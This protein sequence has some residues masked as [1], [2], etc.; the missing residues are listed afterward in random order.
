M[1]FFISSSLEILW[2]LRLI[3][4]ST[5]QCIY[6]MAPSS[7]PSLSIYIH[8]SHAQVLIHITSTSYACH[9]YTHSSDPCILYMY[10][11]SSPALIPLIS[12][13]APNIQASLM[14]ITYKTLTNNR[15]TYLPFECDSC[16]THANHREFSN[17][18]RNLIRI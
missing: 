6:L 12:I 13:G 10:V 2:G 17:C 16:G 3:V 7:I 1:T 14:E 11:G 8:F 5:R 4:M 9:A 15:F 18:A